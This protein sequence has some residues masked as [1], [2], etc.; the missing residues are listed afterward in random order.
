MIYGKREYSV[1]SPD[2]GRV[3][4]TVSSTVSIKQG[5]DLVRL[6]FDEA[7]ALAAD[8]AQGIAELRAGY[9]ASSCEVRS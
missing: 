1:G 3:F 6:S 4:L 2:H 9:P 7:E 5:S 8:L